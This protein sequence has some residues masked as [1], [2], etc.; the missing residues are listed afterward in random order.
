M[1]PC[2]NI[3]DRVASR[4]AASHRARVMDALCARFARST[5]LAALFAADA[6]SSDEREDGA[7][8]S[9]SDSDWSDAEL[10]ESDGAAFDEKP[11][12]AAQGG[13]RPWANAARA[14][15]LARAAA[16]AAA[17]EARTEDGDG[18]GRGS[19]IFLADLPADATLEILRHLSPKDLARVA[20]TR[21]REREMLVSSEIAAAAWGRVKLRKGDDVAKALATIR[22]VARETLR[23][24]DV[25]GVRGVKKSDILA[26][27]SACESLRDVRAVNMGEMG[28]LTTKDVHA[29]AKALGARMRKLT[30]DLGHKIVYDPIRRDPTA[31]YVDVYDENVRDLAETLAIPQLHVRRLKLHSSDPESVRAAA[32]AAASNGADKVESFDASWSL[33]V[34]NEG[35]RAVAEV[36]AQGWDLKRLAL[37]KVNVSDDGAVSLAEA[38]KASADRD[39][40]RL[41]WLDLGSN[42]IRSAGAVALGEAL[43]H[44]GVRITRLT[45]R[46]NGICSV[47]MEALGKGAG[48]SSTLRR[49]DLAHNG[50]GDRGAVAFAHALSRGDAANLRVVLLGFNSIGPDGVRA[51]MQALAHTNVEHLDLGCNV[52]GAEGTKA[53]AETINS[54]RLKSLNLACNNIGLRGD[55]SGLKALA[56]ALETN[57]TL[58]ILNLRGNALHSDC[59]KDIADFLLEETALIQLNIGYNELFDEGAWEIAEALEDN[60]TLLGLDFQRNEITDEGAANIAKT[61]SMNKI[62]QEIDLRSNMIGPD[63]VE[64]LQPY[65]ERTNTRWQ[66]EPPKY[67]EKPKPRFSARKPKSK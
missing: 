30:C 14:R 3:D 2:R 66:L 67:K 21:R 52:V 64:K 34:S 41:R 37:R 6:S 49:L 53:I 36:I 27:M 43:E 24:L 25:S 18:G 29:C 20:A 54:T 7:S 26:T 60:Q 38:I 13:G 32:V 55:R 46:G 8:V 45:L 11:P 35:A 58:E 15:R 5:S 19:G 59:A 22:C 44:P 10:R 12:S 16:R 48:L 47:G 57:T 4:A 1:F 56:K 9:D 39:T 33:R 31:K 51:L 42:D 65:G 50:F 17:R 40:C 63:G 28:K 62:I 61:L 23:E